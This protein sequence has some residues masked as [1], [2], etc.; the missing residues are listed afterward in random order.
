MPLLARPLASA[1]V[2]LDLAHATRR[3]MSGT[4]RTSRTLHYFPWP[5]SVLFVYHQLLNIW[6]LLVLCL[7]V[8]AQDLG[9]FEVCSGLLL[10][11]VPNRPCKFPTPCFGFLMFSVVINNSTFFA[12]TE[13]IKT[14]QK[15]SK[16]LFSLLQKIFP[17]F[18]SLWEP[19]HSLNVPLLVLYTYSILLHH[20]G[21]FLPCHFMS[22]GLIYPTGP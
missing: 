4:T 21:S 7:H 20:V 1:L 6:T 13:Q 12:T 17:Y 8:L 3:S 10:S 14:K 15:K 11:V 16:N 5:V 22:L 18:C 2:F 19:F 9:P